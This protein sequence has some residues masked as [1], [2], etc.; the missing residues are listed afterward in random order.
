MNTLTG[1]DPR[2]LCLAAGALYLLIIVLGMTSEL[3]LRG[4]LFTPGDPA[5]TAAAIAAHATQ[6]RLA[7]AADLTMALADV[8]LA[9]LLLAL[10]WPLHPLMAA[11]ATAFRLIQAATIS[12]N[13]LNQQ[14]ALL[15]LSGALEADA[16][17]PLVQHAMILHAYGYDLGL[18]FFAVNSVLVGL[19]LI[20]APDFPGWLGY[21]LIGS[22]AVYGIGSGLRL[23]APDL[24]AGF[25][26]AYALPLLAETALALWL[27]G[28]GLRRARHGSQPAR[29]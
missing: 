18:A 20:R 11:L 26:P 27:L 9:V 17:Q 21:G 28:L 12:A 4:P 24:A 1:T 8:A 3:A 2:R 22:G 6:F 10:F 13:L 19:L 5:R 29:P 15:L 7:L 14:S 25:A 16:A 23:I